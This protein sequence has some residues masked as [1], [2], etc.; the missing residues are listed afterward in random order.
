[1]KDYLQNYVNVGRIT[2]KQA[3]EVLRDWLGYEF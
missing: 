2:E 3:E 1:M